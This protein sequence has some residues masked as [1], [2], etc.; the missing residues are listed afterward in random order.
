MEEAEVATAS[1]EAVLDTETV[2]MTDV[3][4][5]FVALAVDE[6]TVSADEVT[7]YDTGPTTVALLELTLEA[8][9]LALLVETP[10]L[11]ETGAE[12]VWVS[13]KVLATVVPF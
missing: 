5:D 13:T 1:T 2:R 9:A 12:C 11:A 4:E 7:V 6:E 10:A 3:T 8:V